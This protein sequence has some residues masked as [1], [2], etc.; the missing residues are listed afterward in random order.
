MTSHKE[1]F[2]FKTDDQQVLKLIINSLYSNREIFLREL[3]SNASDA[4]DRLRFKS[5]TEPD[6][7]EGDSEFKIKI[8][9]D[10]E[11]RTLEI[12]DNGIGM[13]RE[14]VIENIGTIAQSGTAAF[15][16]ALENAREEETLTPE[17]IGQFGVGFYS[18][19]IVAEQITLITRAAGAAPD[20]A[21]QWTS[22]GDGTYTLETTTKQERG[23]RVI[24][25]LR[26]GGEDQAD[27][28][29]QEY[30]IR[31][32]VKTHSD[33][34]AYPIVMDVEKE[35]PLSDEEALVDKEGN[36]IEGQTRTVVTEETINSMEAIWLKDKNEITEEEHNEF[37][38]HLS[39]DWNPPLTHLHL[40]LEGVTEYVALLYVP[41]KAPFE[42]FTPER[43]HGVSLYCKR[44]FIMDDCKELFPE[45]LRFIK[46]VVDAP[47][48]NLNVSREILQQAAVVRNIRKNLVKKVLNQFADMETEKYEQFYEELGAVLKEGMHTDYENRDKLT[49]LLRYKTTKS[50]DKWVSLKDYVANMKPDQENIYYITGDNLESLLHH[51]HLEQ[52]KEKDFEVLL[53]T[54]PV[55]E[56]VVSALTEYDGKPLKSAEKGDL[57]LDDV[58]EDRQKDYGEL[59]SH[60]QSALDDKVKEV[61]PS[62]RLR[63]SVACLT[64]DTYDMSAY[65]EKI[66]KASGQEIPASKRVLEVNT[67]H[68]AVQKVK[69]MFEADKEQERL[70]DFIGVIYDLALIGEGGRVE[71][72]ARLSRVV[73]EL[74]AATEK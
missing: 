74:V 35:E 19:F 53:M 24:L 45:Y 4:I 21:V 2:Q 66:L 65:M 73:G 38:K 49:G 64:G 22:A 63:D 47:D 36:K 23:T 68:P 42:L 50:T 27:D 34:V 39:H 26:D 29:T 11:N 58:D 59:F 51:P 69:E 43:K 67:D 46:G 18:A 10:K 28:F 17:L 44:V 14:E 37:Y 52:L 56:W 20:Q 1:T 33:F 12:V 54:D 60:M 62:T 41:S 57:G 70:N 72:P 25:K 3:I 15:L 8:I 30:T 71:N 40:K 55:D 5:Q 48:L 7:L 61:K 6:I 31:R 16:E 13:T 32:I 9:P